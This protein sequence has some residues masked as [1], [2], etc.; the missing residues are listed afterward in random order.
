MTY[1][2]FVSHAWVY[3]D[4]YWD[5]LRLLDSAAANIPNFSY[6]NYSV[7]EHDPI[8]DPS[9]T[10]RIA[11]LKSLL[12]EQIRLSSVVIVPAGMYVNN[13]Y[14]IQAEIEIARNSFLFPKPI[15]ALRRRGQQRDPEDLMQIANT[16]VNWNS[17]SLA[18]AI[19]ELC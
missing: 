19:I 10:V 12:K 17:N 7:P 16:A 15:V 2:V 8:V 9:E 3:S 11:K 4:R 1:N 13:R 5:T 18:R 6:R 14:W